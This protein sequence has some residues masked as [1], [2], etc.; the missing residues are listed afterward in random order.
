[1]PVAETGA[2][3]VEIRISARPALI[4]TIRAVASDLA[5]RADFDLDAISDL[6]MAVDEACTTLV[7]LA[8]TDG[9]L[10]CKFVL[11]H[12]Q[13]EVTVSTATPAPGAEVR[14]DSFGWRVLQTLAD[15]VTSAH[16]I[17]GEPDAIAIRLTKRAGATQ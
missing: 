12:A 14:T 16:G 17:D 13:I 2:A 5:G 8:A 15:E 7:A 3:V 1:V 11:N 9:M 10:S 6:R 4:P